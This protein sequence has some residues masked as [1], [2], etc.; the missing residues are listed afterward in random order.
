MDGVL[1]QI[2]EYTLRDFLAPWLGYVVM[3][4]KVLSNVLREHLWNAIKKLR[5][6]AVKVDAPKVLAV[7]MVIRVTVH[8]EKIRVSKAKA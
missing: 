6:R 8:L 4:P 3:K 2:I 5:D 1:Q 7:D